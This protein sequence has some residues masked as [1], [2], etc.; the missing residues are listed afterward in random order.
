MSGEAGRIEGLVRVPG[1]PY[2]EEGRHCC[3]GRARS[4]ALVEGFESTEG[5]QLGN[6]ISCGPTIAEPLPLTNYSYY[7]IKGGWKRTSNF[8]NYTIYLFSVLLILKF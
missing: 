8:P 7:E 5:L 2:L 3:G 6:L 4:I 1:D